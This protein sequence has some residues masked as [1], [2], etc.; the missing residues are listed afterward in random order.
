MAQ[1]SGRTTV[2]V[3]VGVCAL[4]LGAVLAYVTWRD[5]LGTDQQ[6]AA[7]AP[8]VP[9]ERVVSRR[10]GFSI[11]A[12][13]GMTVRKQGRTVRLAA[14]NRDLVVTVG[15]GKRGTLPR[16]NRHLMADLATKYRRFDRLASE[17]LE[18]G[19]RRALSASGTLTNRAGVRIR[20]VAV[21]VRARPRNY[22]IVAF[23]ARDADPAAVLPRVNAVADGFEILA[24]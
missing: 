13:A 12:P 1:R 10:G 18:V 2:L 6:P 7:A 11:A 17:R 15:P 19:G 5:T 4:V 3:A 8:A 16:A 20:F 22:A 21:T 23:A 9:T 14:E 24:P